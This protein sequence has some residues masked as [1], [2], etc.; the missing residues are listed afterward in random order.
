MNDAMIRVDRELLARMKEV[1]SRHPLKP[2]IRSAV[3]RAV[4][5]MIEDLEEEIRNANR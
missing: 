5:L 3:E 4:E 2:S 1:I